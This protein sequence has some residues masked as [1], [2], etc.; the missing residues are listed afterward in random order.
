MVL[1]RG[2]QSGPCADDLHR[3]F[4]H[5]AA[6]SALVT[7][8]VGPGRIRLLPSEYSYPLHFH[9]RLPNGCRVEFL[10]ELVVPVYED[11]SDLNVLEARGPLGSWL[12]Q[13][14][15]AKA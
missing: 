3:I 5:Q 10:D 14:G 11:E 15:G 9:N 2:F 4:L 13:S 12:R 8:A 7:R 6:L 1:D